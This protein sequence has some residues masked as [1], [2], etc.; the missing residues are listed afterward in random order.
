M[1]EPGAFAAVPYAGVSLAAARFPAIETLN[2]PFKVESALRLSGV[3]QLLIG[4]FA[5]DTRLSMT[6]DWPDPSFI[7]GILPDNHN[8]GEGPG[9]S[10]DWR[11]AYLAR[12]IPGAG[13]NLD[14]S[15]VTQPGMRDMGVRFMREA[16]PY[17]SVE[18]ALKYAAMFVGLVFLAYFLMEVMS[19]SRA[20]PAQYIL[21]GLA[22]AIFYLMLLAFAEKYGF[23]IAFAVAAAM[24]VL[25][26]SAYAM[27][28]FRSFG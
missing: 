6:S 5:K 24:T 4:P 20:H 8:A 13:A 23:D 2:R 11:V 16:N 17:Q 19:G 21:V 27:S 18:R 28:V 15:A 10:A 22:Q 14:V 7:G 12:N 25:L 1:A 3:E 9:F 26:T